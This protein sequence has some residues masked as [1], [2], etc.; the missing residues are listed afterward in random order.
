MSAS[1]ID[2][3]SSRSIA[4]SAQER[5]NTANM[6]IGAVPDEWELYRCVDIS[7]AGASQWYLTLDIQ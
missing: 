1:S 2:F 5:A 4:P 7:A 3:S 6:F